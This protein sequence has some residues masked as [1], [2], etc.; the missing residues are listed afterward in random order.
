MSIRAAAARPSVPLRQV[1]AYAV[2]ADGDGQVLTLEAANGR[3]YLPGGRLERDETP[4]AA[5]LREIEEECGFSALLVEPLGAATQKILDGAVLLEAHY[6]RAR[7][8]GPAAAAP[9]HRL[10]WLSPAGAIGRLHRPGDRGAVAAAFP[11]VRGASASA[12]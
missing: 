1:G 6:W 2:V 10:V 11:A 3:F 9:E 5:L 8:D 4:E 12:R 7:L